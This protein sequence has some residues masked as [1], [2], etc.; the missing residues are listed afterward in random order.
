[1]EA[2]LKSLSSIGS[3]LIALT[4][5]ACGG[6]S[7]DDNSGGGVNNGGSG[8]GGGGQLPTVKLNSSA[9]VIEYHGDSTVW[10][11]RSGTTGE[12]VETP[13]PAAFEAAL[14]N[15]H[16][17]ENMGMNRSTACDLLEGTG[18][19]A[20]LW[21]GY[22]SWQDHMAASNATV[23][24]INHGINDMSANPDMSPEA[25]LGRYQGCLNQLVDIVQS[26][27]KV[28]ILETPNP[29]ADASDERRIS[30][31][32]QVMRNVAEQQGVDLID[33]YKELE[34]EFA[35]DPVAVCPDGV[36][37]SQE[38]YIDKGQFAATEF[39]TFDQP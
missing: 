38:V 36:H 1:M 37:P 2:Y 29:V 13:A 24:I 27:N 32:V 30:D 16:T 19:Y 25:A 31:Y 14:P 34:D 35:A 26:N 18:F 28:V 21:E 11:Y 3:L 5:A 7:S 39:A 15:Y 8:D 20:T 10:G 9:Q 6:G 17:V 23:V 12:R 4:L 33:Q 22:T